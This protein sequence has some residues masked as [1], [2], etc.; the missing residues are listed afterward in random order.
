MA[1]LTLYHFVFNS[2]ATIKI[3]FY[4][5]GEIVELK[6]AETLPR[7]RGSTILKI[8]VILYD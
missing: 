6:L 8:Y 7:I 4:G 3:N 5:G 2:G 1:K